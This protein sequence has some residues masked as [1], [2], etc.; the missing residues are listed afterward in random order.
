MTIH[1]MTNFD[2]MFN[3]KAKHIIYLPRP[4]H[5]EGNMWGVRETEAERERDRDRGRDRERQRDRD[6]DR[7]YATSSYFR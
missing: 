6:R 1:C 4:I 7:A 5:K 3:E 2:S